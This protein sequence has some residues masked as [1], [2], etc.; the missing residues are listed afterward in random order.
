MAAALHAAALA[1]CNAAPAGTV[2]IGVFH[3]YCPPTNLPSLACWYDFETLM[4]N[5]Q[6]DDELCQEHHYACR[7]E[8]IKPKFQC[9]KVDVKTLV[10]DIYSHFQIEKKF[11]DLIL[12]LG[13]DHAFAIRDSVDGVPH[14]HY[15]LP[16]GDA[17]AIRQA[18]G[19]TIPDDEQVLRVYMTH[20]LFDLSLTFTQEEITNHCL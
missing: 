19:N 13:L 15:A 1:H 14:P 16:A 17:N 12:D 4:N 8:T 5:I 7:N 6:A 9:P 20:D 2:T 3:C 18:D 10:K 11:H